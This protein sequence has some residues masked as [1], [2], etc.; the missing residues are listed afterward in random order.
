MQA[1]DM[2]AKRHREEPLGPAG[3]RIQTV[4]ASL[5]PLDATLEP[6]R[7]S[8]AL[9]VGEINQ[10]APN[11]KTFHFAD[12]S[13]LIAVYSG[14]IDFYD[15][16]GKILFGATN[17][18]MQGEVFKMESTVHDVIKDLAA[19]FAAWTPEGI[20]E[21]RMAAMRQTE[22]PPAKLKDAAMLTATALAFIVSHEFGH[23]R[24]YKPPTGKKPAPKLSTEQ[25]I[26]SDAAGIR[27]SLLT[28]TN[29]YVTRMHLAGAVIALRTL[30]IFAD[31]GHGFVGDHP[32][33]LERL[34]NIMAQVRH[35]CQSERDYWWL[36]TIAYAFDEQL[37]D[38]GAIA[39]KSDD[40]APLTADRIFSRAS[41]ILEEVT[42]QR[43]SEDQYLHS[44][45]L[46]LEEAS[47]EVLAAVASI[48]RE[49][50]PVT[51]AKTDNPV[52]DQLWAAEA[53]IFHRLMVQLPA[54]AQAAFADA[55]KITTNAGGVA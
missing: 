26:L 47:P 16:I 30:A 8:G 37:A 9:I 1:A 3:D 29:S 46:D 27:H 23:V 39:L 7:A 44:F 28:P 35:L 55:F 31:M 10:R 2:L 42:K 49:M 48:V 13:H 6:M 45:N 24:F 43:Q 54:R 11:A 22:L 36:T 18:Y 14:L 51:P 5:L 15:S 41:S 32:P 33:P 4:F 20:S 19:L 21:D 40:R 17:L 52:Q 53:A 12:E 25:E 38:A 34:T 50:Y